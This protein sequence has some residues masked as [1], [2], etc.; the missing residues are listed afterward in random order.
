MGTETPKKGLLKE[1]KDF[2]SSIKLSIV[3]LITLAVT[4]IFGTVIQQEKDPAVYVQTYGPTVARIIEVLNL[5]DMYHSWWFQLLL[6]LLLVNI[7]VCS[8]RRLPQAI[9]LMR[10]RDP[11]F[12]GRPVAIQERWEHRVKGRSA[13][14]AAEAVSQVL[15][16]RVGKVERKEVDGKIYL[17]ASKQAWSRMGVYATHASLFLFAVGALVGA[18]WGFKGFVQIPEGTTVEQI[19]LRSGGLHDLGFAVRCDRFELEYY[20]DPEGR[21]TGR[22]KAYRSDL[23]VIEDGEETVQKTIVVNDPLIHQGIFFY[24]ASYGQGGGRWAVLTVFGPRRNILVH[25]E[26]VARGGRVELEEGERLLLRDLTGDFRRMGPAVE[27]A[28]ERPGQAPESIVVFQAAQGNMRRLGDYTV[29]LEE[30]DVVW[31]TGLQVA[32]DPGVP[33]IWAGSFLITLGC[34]VAFLASHRRVWARVQEDAKGTHVFL[35]GNA[36]RNRMSFERRFGELTGRVS[37]VLGS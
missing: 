25:R 30:V 29:R 20:T 6:L 36:S 27:V 35:G 17:F 34:V 26:T 37:E 31:Y 18:Q 33:L 22:P 11:V 1:L 16:E 3:V 12:D 24:Q 4:S 32:Y 5:S 21:P 14:E 15:A 7:T 10:D 13:A 8:I 2:F 9:R 23:V 28:L 19:Q